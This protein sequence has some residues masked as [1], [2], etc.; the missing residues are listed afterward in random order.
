MISLRLSAE[1]YE[2]LRNLYPTYGARSISDFA[3]L[4]MR[5][6]IGGAFASDDALLI[7]L[8]ELDERLSSIEARF[9]TTAQ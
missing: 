7:R 5:R 1:E 6:I 8:R 2:A 3:R 4:A 9:N